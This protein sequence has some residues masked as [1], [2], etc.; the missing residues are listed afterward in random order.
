[1]K[2]TMLTSALVLATSFNIYAS[3]EVC[4]FDKI[5]GTVIEFTTTDKAPAADPIK[6]S[7]N[8]Y[9]YFSSDADGQHLLKKSE[10]FGRKAVFKMDSHK[11]RL[12]AGV[13]NY[14]GQVLDKVDVFSGIADNCKPIFMQIGHNDFSHYYNDLSSFDNGVIN[15][16]EVESTLGVFVHHSEMY[17]VSDLES[18]VGNMYVKANTYLPM[19][20]VDKFYEKKSVLP[21]FSKVDVLDVQH[22]PF[23]FNDRHVSD[24]RIKVIHNGQEGYLPGL[25]SGLSSL[26]ELD[27]VRDEF[28]EA[29]KAKKV[30][31]GM[32]ENELILSLGLPEKSKEF[33][34]YETSTGY[35][36]DYHNEPRFKNMDK[37]GVTKELFYEHIP[38]P[39][40]LS[41][42][43]ILHEGG[44]QFSSVKL[45]G[46]LEFI[47]H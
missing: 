26:N 47:L 11:S 8:V 39:L 23:A 30:A 2:I 13:N 24:Y 9:R 46:T 17:E 10:Y 28:K 43:G 4:G 36:V 7:L 21:P 20:F 45:K 37:V 38:Y 18:F 6:S 22:I 27:S 25:R 3:P 41:Y 15:L 34:V 1:M 19:Y 35:Y 16:Y 5:D 14:T 40:V 33:N 29:V 42:D 12:G 32:T 31:Y 44:Q